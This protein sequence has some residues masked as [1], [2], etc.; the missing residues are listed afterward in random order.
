MALGQE[1]GFASWLCLLPRSC[2][3]L[4]PHLCTG[5]TRV[6]LTGSLCLGHLECTLCALSEH[7]YH[8]PIHLQVP[9]TAW[10]GGPGM[11]VL[12]NVNTM[13]PRPRGHT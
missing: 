4:G 11:C 1:P 7:H 2:L 5:L 12:A 3:C 13:D 8:D 10:P 9:R 6:R